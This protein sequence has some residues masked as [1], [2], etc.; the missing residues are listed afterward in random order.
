MLTAARAT[1]RNLGLLDG[2]LYLM[3]RLLQ[4]VSLG[5]A[6]LISY[7]LVAQP[8]AERDSLPPKRAVRFQVRRL[9]P[10]EAGYLPFPRPRHVIESRFRQG[11]DC[12]GAFRDSEL[13]GFI[14]LRLGPYV[15]DEVRCVFDP[16]PAESTA[17]DFDIWVRP[18]LRLS[19]LFARLWDEANRYL[20]E[21]GV[22]WTFS[23]IAGSN[24]QSVAA[25]RRMGARFLGRATFLV[26]GSVQLTLSSL[27]P[28]MHL[29]LR[30]SALGPRFRPRVKDM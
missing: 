8:V 27:A 24:V 19:P 25:H 17:W 30:R 1:L 10:M 9:L 26:I 3:G 13:V 18:D 22:R 2:S 16:R 28:Y 7:H 4:R 12:F 6:R 20:R 23:R 5:R 29:S 11:A 15:E 21:R 14:W